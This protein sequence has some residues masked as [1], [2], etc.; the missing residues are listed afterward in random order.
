MSKDRSLRMINKN[1]KKNRNSIFKSN[2][3]YELTRDSL[4]K[5]KRNKVKKG[6]YSPSKKET[7]NQK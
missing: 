6:L 5:S 7:L 2:S 4:F 3:L 1:N